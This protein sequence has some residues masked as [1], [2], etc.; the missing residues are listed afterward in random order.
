MPL[1]PHAKKKHPQILAFSSLPSFPPVI[2][3][4]STRFPSF[5]TSSAFRHCKGG[6]LWM[7]HTFM[8]YCPP[9]YIYTQ[10][11]SLHFANSLLPQQATHLTQPSTTPRRSTCTATPQII[12]TKTSLVWAAPVMLILLSTRKAL[13]LM[14]MSLERVLE[15]MSP[16]SLPPS[17][18][19]QTECNW[20]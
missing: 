17:S 18:A 5:L 8:P 7:L 16:P 11:P 1:Y 12:R 2:R 13:S 14:T 15:S 4:I 9:F 6:Y 20:K 10:L 19:Y 3:T